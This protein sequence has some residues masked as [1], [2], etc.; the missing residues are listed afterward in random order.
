VSA[1]LSRAEIRLVKLTGPGGI[2]KTRLG[3][4]VAA[5]L[6]GGYGDG[7]CFVE[8]APISDPSL[9]ATRIAQVLGIADT[10]GRPPVDLLVERVR[11]RR[12]LLVLDNFEQVLDAA[13]IV[14]DLLRSC[15][16]LSILVTSRAPLKLPV[17][18]E[19]PVPPLAIPDPRRPC[20]P[21]ALSQHEAVALFIERATA[22]R[23]GFAVTNANAPAVAGICACLDGLPLAIELA[24]AR[25]RL[26]PPEALLSRLG[27]SL[28][29]LVGGRRDLPA[30]QQTIRS[31]ITWS[32]D[33]LHEPEQ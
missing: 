19:L 28:D 18:H 10:S 11:G 5:E 25:I 24:A 9:V 22:I 17:E 27:H 4:Q 14:D 29:L 13:S 32:F 21:E 20:T 30:R 7:I 31:A 1:L 23:P 12:L 2:G 26:L 33:L 8:L 3:L 16:V 15:P 6:V